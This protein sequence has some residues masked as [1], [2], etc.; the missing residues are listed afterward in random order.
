M[1]GWLVVLALC[2]LVVMVV[3]LYAACYVS[4]SVDDLEQQAELM[5]RLMRVEEADDAD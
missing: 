3:F 2:G 1:P 4:G 5:A